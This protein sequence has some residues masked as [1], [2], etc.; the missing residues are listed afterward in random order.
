MIHNLADIYY[1]ENDKPEVKLEVKPK[2]KPEVKWKTTNSI[3][4]STY[5]L[6]LMK[7]TY[8]HLSANFSKDYIVCIQY[9]QQK[10]RIPG[11]VQYGITETFKKGE[12]EINA[13]LRGIAE[14]LNIFIN[15]KFTDFYK[16]TEKLIIKGKKAFRTIYATTIKINKESEVKLLDS[17]KIVSNKSIDDKTKKMLI[18]IHGELEFLKEKI[19]KF[20]TSEKGICS[21]HLIPVLELPK[22]FKFLDSS[23]SYF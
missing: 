20:S 2:V 6:P 4:P 5:N 17:S 13:S 1:I 22:I 14:E 7:T 11:D 15:H 19:S 9:F 12:D 21:F 23:K 8:D 3:L 10:E 18:V 16:E